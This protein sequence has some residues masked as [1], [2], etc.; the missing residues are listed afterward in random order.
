MGLWSPSPPYLAARRSSLTVHKSGA[1]YS[2]NYPESST[3]N[4]LSDRFHPDYITLS[5][6]TVLL[7]LTL[8]LYLPVCLPHLELLRNPNPSGHGEDKN[9]S[10]YNHKIFLSAKRSRGG[11]RGRSYKR[12]G[13]E[14]CFQKQRSQEFQWWKLMSKM[15][16]LSMLASIT[17][18]KAL[19]SR[20]HANSIQASFSFVKR[21]WEGWE[22]GTLTLDL[23]LGILL[24]YG[25]ITYDFIHLWEDVLLRKFFV[26][27]T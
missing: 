24:G 27:A 17:T 6:Q 18:T 16:G 1:A 3:C 15:V 21:Q 26:V 4:K 14:K 11:E 13:Y 10:W 20:W 19:L 25:Q 5:V 2:W 9:K 22:E 12:S 7:T 23:M 8:P